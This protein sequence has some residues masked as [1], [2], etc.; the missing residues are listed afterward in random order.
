MVKVFEDKFPIGTQGVRKPGMYIDGILQKNLDR[1]KEAVSD[2]WDGVIIVDGV[3]GAGKST[4]AQ[5]IGFYCDPTLT[6]DRVVFSSEPFKK[7]IDK[8][9]KK[10]AIV[11]D[12]AYGALAS[13][14]TMSQM[15]HAIINKLT[16]IRKKNLFLIIVLPTFFDM[17]KYVS[18]WRSR[19]LIHV[20]AEGFDRG[21]FKFYNYH[22]KKD[23]YVK[24]KKF[25]DYKCVFPNF[26]GRFTNFYPCGKEEYLK[27]KDE[28]EDEEEESD[29][30]I[31]QKQIVKKEVMIELVPIFHKKLKQR[32]FT[33]QE[34]AELLGISR[35]TF[36]KYLYSLRNQE[37][38]IVSVGI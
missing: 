22:K 1:L 24:G 19:C 13:K 20:V 28:A 11:Y 17:T 31:R 9:E 38:D 6:L 5:Q 26:S 37:K 29:L 14:K 12:E 32:G 35:P 15:T 7:A 2:D 30:G 25:Y 33:Q 4:L 23:L 21:Y 18:L 36:K 10:Q 27:K 34:M 3:E 16:R 8:A